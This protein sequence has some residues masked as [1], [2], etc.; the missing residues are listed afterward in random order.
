[1][2]SKDYSS[3]VMKTQFLF[4]TSMAVALNILT[5]YEVADKNIIG[6]NIHTT[7]QGSLL[8]TTGMKAIEAR[9][10]INKENCIF[11]CSPLLGSLPFLGALCIA[12]CDLANP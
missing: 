3:T 10:V 12:G 5:N 4:V 8:A 2:Q 6:S 11:N 7:S 9:E 1:M